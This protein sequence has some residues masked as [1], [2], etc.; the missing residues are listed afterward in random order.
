MAFISSKPG[1]GPLPGSP[2]KVYRDP[3][4][5]ELWKGGSDT[6]LC[7]ETFEEDLEEH[8]EEKISEE[9]PKEHVKEPSEM[10][11]GKL[12]GAAL[13]EDLQESEEKSLR[14]S[15]IPPKKEAEKRGLTSILGRPSPR[16]RQD[17]RR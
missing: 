9:T 1:P 13:E 5:S 15:E 10:K 14:K 7:G 17:S 16:T 11:A 3:S 2:W 8:L 4:G 12:D 6:F